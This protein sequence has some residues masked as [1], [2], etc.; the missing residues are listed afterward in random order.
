MAMQNR[1]GKKIYAKLLIVLLIAA[2]LLV[3]QFAVT[4]PADGRE[5]AEPP[6]YNVIPLK[7]EDVTVP[8]RYVGYVTPVHSVLI[9]P[10]ISG[11]LDK[12]L[13]KGGDEV[14]AGQLLVTIRQDEY[15]ARLD[16]AKAAVLQAEADYNNADL[17]YQRVKKAGG[18]A[19]SKTELD[20]AKARFLSAQAALAQAKANRSL[21][22]TT[23]D[24]TEIKAP[25]D[26]IVG[27][28]SLTK[29]EYV[30]PASKPLLSIIQ[31]NPIRV[32]FSITDK[33]YLNEISKGANALFNGD[34]IKLR[35]A[36]GEIFEKEGQ[37]QFAD[38]AVDRKTNSIAVFADFENERRT[39]V[40]NAYVDVLLDKVYENGVLI[41]QN[42]VT[43][44]SNE[45]YVYIVNNSELKRVPIEIVNTS[46]GSYLVKNAFPQSSWL[47]TDKVGNYR[48]GQK[49]KIKTNGSQPVMPEKK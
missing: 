15:K 4:Q 26:G 6:V 44:G 18:Q 45:N 25:I 22:Q 3:Y 14:K 47:V 20:N 29:G 49:V 1:L 21:A 46:D 5:E 42:L 48:A 12:I 33:D 41:P 28:V 10:Y 39:L 32:V 34:K 35:L 17:Y 27:N 38:N 31:T 2:V 7:T 8:N 11:Y 13:V 23:F 36:N 16:A 24:Y 30:S 43:L 37:F 40:A 19:V 9:M